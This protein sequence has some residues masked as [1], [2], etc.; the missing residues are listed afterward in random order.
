MQH[1]IE[2]PLVE[3]VSYNDDL[4]PIREF[5]HDGDFHEQSMEVNKSMETPINGLLT[6]HIL[7]DFNKIPHALVIHRLVVVRRTSKSPL[8]KCLKIKF[9]N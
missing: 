8:N 3:V 4:S 9:P 7:F 5:S 1:Q 6:G 2:S